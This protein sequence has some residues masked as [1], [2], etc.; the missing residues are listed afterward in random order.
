MKLKLLLLALVTI[1]FSCE[2]NQAETTQFE[3]ATDFN[4]DWK[5][6]LV[7]DTTLPA[8]VPLKDADWR[9]IRLPHDWSVELPFSEE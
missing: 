1:V 6:T 9:N 5:F 4:F 3:R 8:Q 2:Q 7:K